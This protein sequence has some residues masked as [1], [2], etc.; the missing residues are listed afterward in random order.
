[1][2]ASCHQA[3]AGYCPPGVRGPTH[4]QYRHAN[5][6][7]P[8]AIVHAK[9]H[10]RRQQGGVS[11]QDAAQLT[12]SSIVGG[13]LSMVGRVT[14][15]MDVHRTD[16]GEDKEMIFAPIL[17]HAGLNNWTGWH[18][19]AL[20]I[21][22]ILY[23]LFKVLVPQSLLLG[24]SCSVLIRLSQFIVALA[25][26]LMLFAL[27]R[28]RKMR[29]RS[30]ILLSGLLYA[31]ITL[32]ANIVGDQGWYERAWI[33]GARDRSIAFLQHAD[34]AEDF[35]KRYAAGIPGSLPNA[36]GV[37]GAFRRYSSG[38]LY[39]Y[40]DG[41]WIVIVGNNSFS[42]EWERLPFTAFYNAARGSNGTWLESY[43]HFSDGGHMKPLSALGS[44]VSAQTYLAKFGFE[45]MKQGT[46]PTTGGTVRR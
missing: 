15:D 27:T 3:A 41:S 25:P 46:S 38:M 5:L 23:P 31:S 30:R 35:C 24:S 26:A 20:L 7:F 16:V 10:S 37:D 4:R 2:L 12:I 45:P 1:M 13:H 6:Q 22:L 8:L 33:A 19:F 9:D 34:T 18:T 21:G 11:H 36:F 17:A 29:L 40:P 44:V 39:A 42:G 43:T 32:T 28:R 14:S